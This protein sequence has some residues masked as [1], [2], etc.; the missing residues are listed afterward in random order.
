MQRATIDLY[1]RVASI[2]GKADRNSKR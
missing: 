2:Q 1:E